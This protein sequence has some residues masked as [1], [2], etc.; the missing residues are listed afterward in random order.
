M[1][2]AD[3]EKQQE[4]PDLEA[5]SLHETAGRLKKWV[6]ASSKTWHFSSS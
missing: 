6:Q 4:H 1:K 2:Q 5:L 3:A